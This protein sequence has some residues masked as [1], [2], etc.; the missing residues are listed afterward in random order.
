MTLPQMEFS[1]FHLILS[2]LNATQRAVPISSKVKQL[3]L[4]ASAKDLGET[5]HGGDL[6]KGRRK[7]RRPF[8]PDA[9]IHLVLKS[10]RAN[11]AWSLLHRRNRSRVETLIYAQ[12]NHSGV[13]VYRHA[14]AGNHIHLLIRAYS[15]EAFRKFMRALP[16]L[17]ARHVTQAKKGLAKG[18]FWDRIPYSRLIHWGREY[19]LLCAYLAKNQIEAC[20]FSG[21][22][23]RF[24]S[25]GEA[26]I[27]VGAPDFRLGDKNLIPESWGL[28]PGRSRPPE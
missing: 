4:F 25:S 1:K 22:R 5:E 15:Q 20:G 10:H 7:I 8:S 19:R 12:A 21:A 18:R 16:A 26:V 17:I 14:N 24:T 28:F 11:G 6:N 2:A 23:L 13:K 27:V 3:G 9:P